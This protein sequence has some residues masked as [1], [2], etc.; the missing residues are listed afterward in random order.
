MTNNKNNKRKKNTGLK[1]VS[2]LMAGLTAAAGV[3]CGIG[4]M[5]AV[6]LE[7]QVNELIRERD[8]NADKIPMTFKTYGIV[9]EDYEKYGIPERAINS[10]LIVADF[11]PANTTDKRCRW[12]WKWKDSSVTES[13]EDYVYFNPA[14]NNG[15]NCAVGCLKAFTKTI[16][17]TCTSVADSKITSTTNIEYVTRYSEL[18]NASDF[19]MNHFT[20][21]IN[22]F[23]NMFEEEDNIGTVLPDSFEADVKIQ[24][25]RELFEYLHQEDYDV[26]E[27]AEYKNITGGIPNLT[28]GAIYGYCWGW[29]NEFNALH[30]DDVA[31]WCLDNDTDCIG[32][33]TATV[34]CY[35]KGELIYEFKDGKDWMLSAGCLAE[36]AIPPQGVN[37]PPEIALSL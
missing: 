22:V 37:T 27:Y 11:T 28:D 20:D 17:L 13:V 18:N 30:P 31:K 1:V 32:T 8:D 15:A 33:I 6:K 36:M 21:D 3:A 26:S 7:K 10:K 24:I 23:T 2:V 19:V 14:A 4:W 34:R 29:A 16:V 35:Y 9:A 25:Y 5:K 12:T